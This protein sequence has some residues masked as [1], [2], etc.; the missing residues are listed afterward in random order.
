VN[1]VQDY[2]SSALAQRGVQYSDAP[3]VLYSGA[4]ESGC[5][6][7][8]SATGPFYCPNDNRVYL[9]LSFFDDLRTQLGAQGG[10]FAQAYVIAHEY[11][12]HVQDLDGVFDHIGTPTDGPTGTSVRLE[13][14]ADCYAGVWAHH[15]QDSN[16]IQ[17]VT[18]ADIRDAL[19]AAAA[20]GDDRIQRE[21]TGHVQP[22]NFTHGTSD[23][24]DRWF[25]NGYTS[26]NMSTCDTFAGA[27][28]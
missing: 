23:Q 26:G 10:E 12:H 5:G 13:L 27:P 24:R 11:G 2:W 4:T 21:E 7:A 22:D 6:V 28:L 3:T 19:N 15:A 18:P 8:S 20:V 9:D 1:S 17:D 16:I 14:Q 25:T